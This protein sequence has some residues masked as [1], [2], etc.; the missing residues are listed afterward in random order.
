[1]TPLR[2][3]YEESYVRAFPFDK[4]VSEMLDP[5]MIEDSAKIV[6]EGIEDNVQAN[7]I[8]T[9]GLAGTPP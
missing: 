3:S 1:M 7:L 5:E 8:I 6:N 2:M 9:T 4:V